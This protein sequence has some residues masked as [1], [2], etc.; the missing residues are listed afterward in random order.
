MTG[1]ER[2]LIDVYGGPIMT[3]LRFNRSSLGRR[4]TFAHEYLPELRKGGVAVFVWPVRGFD[5][6]ALAYAEIRESSGGVRIVPDLSGIL[7]AQRTG[8]LAVLLCASFMGLG[9]NLDYLA[10][11]AQLGVTLFSLTHNRRTPLADGC[12]ERTAGGLTYFG[13]EV[14]QQLGKLGLI[15]D[16]SHISECGFWDVLEYATGPVIAT[17]SNA[18]G[19]ADHPRNLTDQQIKALADAGGMMAIN[20][21]P[22]LLG[23]SSP[24]IEDV[25]R[26]IDYVCTLVGVEYVGLGPDYMD[27]ATELVGAQLRGADP[28]GTLYGTTYVYPS[29]AASIAELGN[30]L[31]ALI[32]H[33][34]STQ[35]VDKIA[36]QNF[37]RVLGKIR[38]PQSLVLGRE[39]ATSQD[40]C[41]R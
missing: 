11:F 18:R 5:D 25:V 28:T 14:V 2:L 36:G 30:V 32:C 13:I 12:G 17:H 24:T 4:A 27:Y 37:L 9:E 6:I 3:L 22:D 33:G 29:G 34:Y 39:F 1:Q 20:F 23:T 21:H 26:Q 38:R 19:L 41:Y 35:D 7:E 15:T 40:D 31:D 10:T 8:V 16:V